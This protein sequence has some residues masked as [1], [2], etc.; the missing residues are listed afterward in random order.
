MIKPLS[1]FLPERSSACSEYWKQICDGLVDSDEQVAG[2]AF[3]VIQLLM[4][5]KSTFCE[6]EEGM[7][8]SVLLSRWCHLCI[9]VIRENLAA[10]L[11]QSDKLDAAGRVQSCYSM[12][13]HGSRNE[14]IR[15]VLWLFYSELAWK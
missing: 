3:H 4:N 11:Y 14:W 9:Q 15:Y 13:T 7:D 5:K 12:V 8:W 1:K 10:V 6:G 2:T